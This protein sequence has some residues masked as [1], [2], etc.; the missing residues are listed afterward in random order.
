VQST[1]TSTI[2]STTLL[3]GLSLIQTFTG[4]GDI[5]T[6]TFQ[7]DKSTWEIVWSYVAENNSPGLWYYIYQP[8]VISVLDIQQSGGASSGTSYEY[9]GPGTYYI[10]INSANITSWT[11]QVYG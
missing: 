9:F 1:S 6:P 3:P 5:S 7:V 4:S 10:G 2:P 8:G 11:I